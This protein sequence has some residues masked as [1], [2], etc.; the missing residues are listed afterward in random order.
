MISRQKA[1]FV[2][3]PLLFLFILLSDI[4]GL[5][6]EAKSIAASTV[7]IACWWLT[8]AIPIP[9]TSLLPIILFPL[10]GALEVGKVTAEYGNQIIFLLI[11][12]FFIAIAMEKWGL[13]IRIAL[14]IV[15]TIGTSPR[16]TIAGFMGA[17]AFIS[18]WISN[19]ATAMMMVPIATAV[20]YQASKSGE[21]KNFNAAM[22]LSVAYAASIG[23]IATLIG[24]TP[25]LI[26]AGV[27]STL[28]GKEIT[29]LQWAT[30][31]FPLAFLIL[32]FCWAYLVYVAYP[33]GIKVLGKGIKDEIDKPGKIT[34]QEKKVLAV[35]LLV[36]ALWITRVLWGKY[37]PMVSD[38]GIAVFGA[39]LLFL[40]P[41]G[42]GTALL[43]WKDTARLPWDVVLLLGAGLSIAKGFTETG[44]EVFIAQQLLFLKGIFEIEIILSVV[45]LTIF[46]TE[47]TSNTATA[48]I[49]IPV[50]A[51]LAA[52]LGM[53]PAGLMVAAA[54]S[55][56]L[57]FMLP[58]ATPPNA[59]V[60]GTGYVTIP[61]M[62]R[63]GLWMNLLC[64][65]IIT[66]FIMFIQM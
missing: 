6:W 24:T 32:V 25:N 3:G 45:T 1:G 54:I 31:G 14:L 57:A 60:F 23:G 46:L 53:E 62:A 21:D 50:T 64:I 4:E 41:A 10:L 51:S 13:H 28:Y 40:I 5:S 42:K 20:I 17:T 34:S 19:T 55:S 2:L 63:A 58:V 11:G 61:Q 33:P 37:L 8:E 66:L 43:I 12:G 52:A 48:T 29:F 35:F 7:W 56:S 27:Y 49:I 47:I 30:Y 59:I 36:A 65:A 18:A 15:R 44:L 26:F 9:A 39:L 22:M 38:A 16:R